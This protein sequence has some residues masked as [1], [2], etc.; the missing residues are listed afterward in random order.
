MNIEI[1]ADYNALSKKA[2]AIVL[3]KIAQ[4]PELVLALPTGNSPIGMYKELVQTQ[5]T[6]GADLSRI[7]VFTLDEYAHLPAADPHSFAFFM[8]CHLIDPLGI[9]S[10]F[11]HIQGEAPD[12]PAECK[13]YE[14][15]IAA[16]GGLDLAVL[17]L[18]VNGHIAFNEPGTP[19]D[20]RTQL[21]DLTASTRHANADYFAGSFIIP[22]QGITMGIGTILEAK[23]IL[24]LASGKSKA[25][26]VARIFAS[27]PS[28]GLP[29]S[30]LKEHPRVSWLLDRDAAADYN[31]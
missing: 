4:K 9:E 17:G 19:F 13:R 27:N 14:E 7:W 3:N 6:G 8:Q 28:P 31:K 23:E 2:A 11:D 29:A 30:A 12:L 24:V 16:K 22:R 25:Q 1:V 10:R 18:G 15:A 5:Q 21:V 26:I 20:S